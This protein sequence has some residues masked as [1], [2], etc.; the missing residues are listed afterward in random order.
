MISFLPMKWIKISGAGNTFALMDAR[1]E[2][3]WAQFEKKSQNKNNQFRPEIVK[4]VCDPVSGVGVDGVLFIEEGSQGFDYDWDFYNA[5]GSSAEMCGNAARCAARFCAEFLEKKSSYQFKTGAGLVTAQLMPEGKVQVQMPAAQWVN[6]DLTL[7]A[8]DKTSE[9]FSL[10]NTGVPHLVQ[11]LERFEQVEDLKAMAREMRS[12]PT[13]MPQGS[14]VTFYTVI[15]KNQIRAVTFERG[16]ENYTRACGTG[17]VAAAMVQQSLSSA[18][19]IEVQ[20]PGGSIQ[21]TFPPNDP[22]PLMSG[23]AVII[24]EFHSSHEVIK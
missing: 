16:V 23:S 15:Q 24:G 12:H 1:P 6:K 8:K 4:V 21:V 10:V 14:N 11:R 5:D 17:A 18:N 7:T 13:L 2:S 20:M 22:H 19:D 9:R 3:A